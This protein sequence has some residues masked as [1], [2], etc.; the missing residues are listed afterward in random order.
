MINTY[1]LI[2]YF[3]SHNASYWC[4]NMDSILFSF[5]LFLRFHLLFKMLDI[6]TFLK[7]KMKQFTILSKNIFRVNS[8]HL[9]PTSDFTAWHSR[10]RVIGVFFIQRT[11]WFLLIFCEFWTLP[12]LEPF[13]YQCPW[14]I[15][16]YFRDW[17]YSVRSCIAFW[18]RKKSAIVLKSFNKQLIIS[19][20]WFWN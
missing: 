6:F 10:P 4:G 12:L 11:S 16:L 2:W 1:I 8:T 7:L 20:L 5:G 18:K 13:F 3:I 14:T 9:N 17:H 15:G 19:K